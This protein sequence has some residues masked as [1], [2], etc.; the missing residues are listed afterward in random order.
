LKDGYIGVIAVSDLSGSSLLLNQGG[1]TVGLKANPTSIEQGQKVSITAVVQATLA[2]RPQPTG[3]VTLLE[4]S[5]NLGSGTLSEGS[6][7]NRCERIGRGQSFYRRA[8][9]R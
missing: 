5:T 2:G 9:R 1:S 3:T 7:T 8:L 6:V 4:G